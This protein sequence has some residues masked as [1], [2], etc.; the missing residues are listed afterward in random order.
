MHKTT[1]GSRKETQQNAQDPNENQS[2]RHKTRSWADDDVP[3]D[4]QT[5]KLTRKGKEDLL[6]DSQ[7]SIKSL[8][9]ARK[10]LIEN[11]YIIEGEPASV[12]TMVTALLQIS[13]GPTLVVREMINGIRAVAIYLEEVGRVEGAKEALEMMRGHVNEIIDETK[14]KMET[15]A[16]NMQ[17]LAEEEGVANRNHHSRE[18]LEE[19]ELTRIVE[20]VIETTKKKPTYAEA[21]ARAEN[22][23][24]ASREEQIR[25][26][27]LAR[28]ELQQRQIILDGDDGMVNGKLTPKEMITKANLAIEQISTEEGEDIYVGGKPQGAQFV[29]ARTLKNGGVLLEMESEEGA[30]WLKD[31]DIKAKFE[32]SFP[33][34]V[35]VKGRNYQVVVQF[36]ST[37]LKDKLET[38]LT[39][40][41][42]EN[43]FPE[44]TILK[45]RWMRNPSNWSQTQL[46]AHAVISVPSRGI[47]NM[48][49]MKGLLIEGTRH[50]ARKLEEDPKRCFRCQQIG[51]G[52]TA[53][54]CKMAE[55]C[56]NCSGLHSTGECKANRAEFRCV[57]CKKNKQPD[58]HASW[59]RRCPAFLQEK[60]RLRERQ[61]E[62]YYRYYPTAGDQTTWV[63]HEESFAG[64]AAERWM[65]NENRP[66]YSAAQATQQDDGWGR[67]LGTG[68]RRGDT[69]RPRM[70]D[71]YVPRT[72]DSYVPDST[73][74]LTSRGSRGTQSGSNGNN[75]VTT[76]QNGHRDNSRSQS[77]GRTTTQKQMQSKVAGTRQRSLAECWS[78]SREPT[79]RRHNER[80]G[81]RQ[82][83]NRYPNSSKERR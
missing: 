11:K 77:R 49:M 74:Q 37:R 63:T 4:T 24:G 23:K 31:D 51:T 70:V 41:E 79:E 45:A 47:A 81:Q 78:R 66:T 35:K 3:I 33:G 71:S 26:D 67:P 17:K 9:T 52:H 64:K 16:E 19:E 27:V 32:K 1:Q 10:W 2:T 54:T 8:G 40:I 76:S 82:R 46:K 69:W 42:D 44:D 5:A 22:L 30:D 29:A 73:S 48:I 55:A 57:T 34:M 60:A 75:Q 13:S 53:A 61:P 68:L 80:G 14:G 65:G 15:I 83:E 36:I 18:K 38:M 28:N 20:K 12:S 50:D 58:D 72:T 7:S 6:K 25:Q 56:S 59:D 21:A 39:E 62:N 43:R